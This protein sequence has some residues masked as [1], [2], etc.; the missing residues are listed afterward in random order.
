MSAAPEVLVAGAGPTGLTAACTL[1]QHGVPVRLVDRRAC[2]TPEPKALVMWSGALEALHRLGV[3]DALAE[4]A[5]PLNG[6]SYWSGGR[7]LA[8]V[9][10]GGLSGTRFPRPLCV[11]Q[12]VTEELLY[13]RLLD[14][15]G[16]VEWG[17]AVTA[18]ATADGRAEVALTRADGTA[19]TVSVPWLIGADGTRSTVRESIGVPYPG[20]SHDREFV[21]GDGRIDGDLPP[22][23]AQ[24][25]L[26]PDG[27]LVLVALPDGGHRIF[28]DLPPGTRTGPPDDAE[29]QQLLDARGHGRWTVRETWWTSR[30]RVHTKVAERFRHGPVLLAGDAAH[31]HSPAGG[32]GLN[33]G[34]QD[35]FDAGWK[36]AAV[37]RGADP[38]LLDSYDPERR[39]VSAR[40][41]RNSERQT[42]LW[43]LRPRPARALRDLLLGTLARTGALERRIVP[44]LAQLDLDLTASPA[45]RPTTVPGAPVPGRRLGD[46]PLRPLRGTSATSLHDYLA[47]GRHTVLIA[48]DGPA[49]A[50]AA[51]R[52]TAELTLRGLPDLTD[53]LLLLPPG[54]AADLPAGP[55]NP[56]IAAGTLPGHPP[57]PGPALACLLRP[58]GVVA[59]AVALD[60]P[61]GVDA[62]LSALPTGQRSAAPA[63]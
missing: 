57:T 37:L 31:A 6:A 16:R 7:R 11:P 33:T 17:T 48:G 58:D 13:E 34:V 27:V 47:T 52:A 5:L 10:F 14:L 25:H 30:F 36:L 35:G 3:A 12:P 40:A 56:D 24:Y 59:G 55:A 1:L 2:F 26:S 49:A 19:E 21:L 43:L 50:D 15:G 53:V 20:S 22:D 4:R 23:E 62:L 9:R 51:E 39:P 46:A 28:F 60:R 8:G 42:R 18:V 38:A 54:T 29:L 63:P 44:E 41:V 32:Q 45:V 61:D